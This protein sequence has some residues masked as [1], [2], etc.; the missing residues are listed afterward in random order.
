MHFLYSAGAATQQEESSSECS[1]TT[2]GVEDGSGGESARISSGSNGT[3]SESGNGSGSDT[4]QSTDSLVA[5]VT[6]VGELKVRACY[7]GAGWECLLCWCWLGVL[8]MM[9]LV[10]SVC[11]DGAGWECLLVMMVLVGSA[12]WSMRV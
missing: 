4:A 1:S 10:G 2:S 5:D 12:A 7:D 3:S 8:V 11:Y 9:V 6:G